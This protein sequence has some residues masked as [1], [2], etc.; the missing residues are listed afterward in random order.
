MFSKT[1]R[2]SLEPNSLLFNVYRGSLGK[3]SECEADH[4]PPS[5]RKGLGPFATYEI[6]CVYRGNLNFTHCNGGSMET[7]ADLDLTTI[8]DSAEKCLLLEDKVDGA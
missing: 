2:P 7:T 3:R 4:S 8:P 1:S 5:S 6:N